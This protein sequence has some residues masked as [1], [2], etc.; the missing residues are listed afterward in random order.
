MNQR[1]R[2]ALDNHI[3]GHYGEDQYPE[4][5]PKECTCKDGHALDGGECEPASIDELGG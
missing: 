4:Q 5:G 1:E 3:T 2:D